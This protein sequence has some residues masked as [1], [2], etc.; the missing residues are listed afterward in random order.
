MKWLLLVRPAAE[1]DLESAR[2]WYDDKS[3]GL[4]DAFLDEVAVA[5]EISGTTLD[6][7]RLYY[8]HFRRLLLRR[9]LYKIFHQMIGKRVVIF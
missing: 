1:R 3:P 2:D 8:R 4:G 7:Q 5:M 9:F 6:S